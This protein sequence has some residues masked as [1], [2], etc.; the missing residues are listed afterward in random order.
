MI[1]REHIHENKRSNRRIRTRTIVLAFTVRAMAYANATHAQDEANVKAGLE[2]WKS[3][4]CADCY[5]AFADGD[6]QRDEAPTGAN[7]R[8]TRLDAAALKLA[9]G[10]GRP[11]GT[12]MPAF[13]EGAYK[14]RPCYDRPLGPAPDNLY[15]TPRTLTPDQIDAVV[16]YLLARIVGRGRITRAE[17]L[18]HYED[19]DDPC[20]DFK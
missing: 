11:G 15:P 19:Q 4:G 7:L 9:I 16:A 3:S 2:V 8:T 10:C 13:E 6:K 12:G 1:P 17:C 5:G 18:V 14:V 20:E